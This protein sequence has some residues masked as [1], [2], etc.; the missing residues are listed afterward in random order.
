MLRVRKY[1]NELL[2]DQLPVLSHVQVCR[3]GVVFASGVVGCGLYYVVMSSLQ[4]YLDEVTVVDPPP[5]M[6]SSFLLEQTPAI[7]DAIHSELVNSTEVAEY[8]L[9]HVFSGDD[10]KDED[11][12][13]CFLD[14][15]PSSDMPYL[16]F[17]SS[18]QSGECVHNGRFRA[19][20][21]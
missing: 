8:Q 3:C 12:K 7:R 4:R 13:R 6:R 18:L 19:A 15:F 17:V 14:P 10:A 2:L 21:R 5:A 16:N 1:L 11:L 9:A 20:V